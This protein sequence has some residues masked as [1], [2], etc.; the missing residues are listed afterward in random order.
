[1]SRPI[2]RI[3]WPA[4]SRWT[5][6]RPPPKGSLSP[7]SSSR[8]PGEQA[9][10]VAEIALASAVEGEPKRL[11]FSFELQALKVELGQQVEAGEVLCSLWPIT[12]R[13]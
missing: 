10:K 1:M 8:A 11:P 3:C 13:C 7:R 2:G 12:A 6:S 9:L 5:G 4:D